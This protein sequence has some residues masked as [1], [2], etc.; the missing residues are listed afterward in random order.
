MYICKER[1]ERVL[2][3]AVSSSSCVN[4]LLPPVKNSVVLAVL[5]I[6]A[7]QVKHSEQQSLPFPV[8]SSLFKTLFFLLGVAQL[9]ELPLSM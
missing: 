5:E 3:K 7:W 9:H 8:M 6:S 2:K 1:E 4:T